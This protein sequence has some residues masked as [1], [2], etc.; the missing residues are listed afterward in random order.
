VA[1]TSEIAEK[2]VCFVIPREAGNLSSI[3]THQ[4]VFSL[5]VR[6]SSRFNKNENTKGMWK[7]FFA[8]FPTGGEACATKPSCSA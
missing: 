3:E 7:S 8:C 4:L 6:K 2:E 5:G 1:R